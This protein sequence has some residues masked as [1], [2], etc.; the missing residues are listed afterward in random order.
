MRDLVIEWLR[1]NV[2]PPRLAHI[3]GVE[4][5]ARELAELHH[6]D[7]ERAAW[8]GLLHD[9]A[10]YFK[11]ERLLTMAR[12]EGL[13]LDPVEIANP[14]LLHAEASAL[15]ARD[16]FGVHDPEVLEAVRCHTLGRPG[17]SPLACVVYLADAIEPG[18]GN[19]PEL[20]QLRRL[21]Q[22]D[23]YAAIGLACDQTLEFLIAKSRLIHPRVISVRNWALQT[24]Q[25]ERKPILRAQ[26]L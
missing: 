1:E 17:M 14:H 25:V 4:Q 7:A 16:Q 23:L 5:T 8:A 18:R 26:S 11:A 13:L 9:L 15:V 22:S 3:L 20:D 12:A 2:P 19:S 10:K 24:A 6:L 21:S